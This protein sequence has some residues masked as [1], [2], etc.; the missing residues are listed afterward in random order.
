MI[1]SNSESNII[2]DVRGHD[3]TFSGWGIHER[4][5]VHAVEDATFSVNT[6]R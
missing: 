4:P 6:A 2:L 3:Q 5:V 1:R